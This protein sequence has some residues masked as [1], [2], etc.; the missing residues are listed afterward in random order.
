M[1]KIDV[2]EMIALFCWGGG[3]GM[4]VSVVAKKM[5]G[6]F[7]FVYL[8]QDSTGNLSG[9]EQQMEFFFVVAGSDGYL[10]RKSHRRHNS[11]SIY[12][13]TDRPFPFR[14]FRESV[15]L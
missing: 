11:W 6:L 3:W 5:M 15:Y 12:K 8:N 14:P 2:P 10:A 7:L 1:A 13:V 4:I 9:L